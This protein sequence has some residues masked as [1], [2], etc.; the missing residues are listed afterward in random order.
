LASGDTGNINSSSTPIWDQYALV[1]QTIPGQTSVILKM[2]N[3]GSGGCGND[4]AIDD[5]A[6][7]ACG[8]FITVTDS[9]NNAQL[10]ICENETPFR[11]ELTATL[12][13]SVYSSHFYQWQES[14]DGL[15]WTDI[16]GETSEMINVNV[17][18]SNFYRTKVAEDLVNIE[19]SQCI[20]LSDVFQVNVNQSP[21]AP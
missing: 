21:E 4:F 20:S 19:N 10:D 12:D 5:I 16:I 9:N 3:N 8:D 2:I 18:G 1:F 11:L 14:F 15:L 13:F 17:T 6:F 7:S